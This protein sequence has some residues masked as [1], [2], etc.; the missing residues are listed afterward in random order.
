[1]LIVADN[2]TLARRDVARAVTQVDAAPIQAIVR[3]SVA[4]GAQAID[5]NPG[6]L[7][8]APAERMTF[9]VHAV[10]EVTRLPLILDTTNPVALRAGLAACRGPAVINGFSL[11]PAKIEMILPLALEFDTDIIG[12]ILT[13]E[14]RVPITEE[15]ML[16]VAVELFEVFHST[17]LP[18]ERLIIDPVVLPLSWPDGLEHNRNLLTLIRRLPDLLGT[19][20]RSIVGLSNLTSGTLPSA[21]K[22]QLESAF[23]PM[24]ATAGLN[25]A[26]INMEHT[27]TVATARLC[28][29]LLSD[30][31]FAWEGPPNAAIYKG[32]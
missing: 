2:L 1:M 14:S 21:H 18:P 19:P 3:R 4:A 6:P 32:G 23:L 15:E 28:R 12:Y 30:T 17:G 9:L 5:I 20:L 22:N 24:L 8:R 29:A 10:L 13:A 27:Q 26:L 16:S 25:L 31:V 7:T 11:E